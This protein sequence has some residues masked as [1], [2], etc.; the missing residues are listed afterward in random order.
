MMRYVFTLAVL[1]PTMAIDNGL[2][3]TPP[4]GWNSWNQFGCNVSESLILS[5]AQAMVDTGLA[6]LGYEYVNIDDCWQAQERDTNG[7]LQADTTRFPN[8]ISYVATTLHDMGLKLGIYSDV[9]KKTCQGYP[10]SHGSYDVDA[11]TLASWGVDFLKFDTCSLTF[12][13]RRDPRDDYT[14]MSTALNTTGRPILYSICNWGKHDP[15]LWAPNISNMWRTTM[16]IYPQYARVMSIVD[17]QNGL[18]EYA[19]PGHWNDPDMVEVGVESTIFNWKH[20]PATNITQRE[21]M[22]HFSLWSILSAP[23]I[24]G[25]DLTS[26]P[27]WALDI[28]SN[29]EVLAVSQDPL[30]ATGV[31]V[32][33]A[34]TGVM[35]GGVCTT[36]AC[37]HTQVFLKE[38]A[39][40]AFAAVL[41]NRG[42][43][44]DQDDAHF[45]PETIRLDLS[46]IGEGSGLFAVRDL[47]TGEDLGVFEGEFATPEG[48]EPH[49]AVMVRLTPL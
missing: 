21:S 40:G 20:M 35:V 15:W 3:L 7:R 45:V 44:Y 10:G 36:G 13:E 14:A 38:L 12:E 22:A 8:G 43:K 25:L 32:A 23:I 18:A 27:A 31:S 39:G 48:V 29:A 47:W 33:E 19:G 26:A 46:T 37:S 1:A 49:A 6:A 17:A 28:V 4:M 34:T 2:A 16:D 24:L 42:G 9:G 30:G 5:Q 41:I 11:E